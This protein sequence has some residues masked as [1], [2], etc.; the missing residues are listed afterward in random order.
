MLVHRILARKWR[1]AQVFVTGRGEV[2]DQMVRALLLYV[3][4]VIMHGGVLPIAD[5][6]ALGT[7]KTDI[8]IFRTS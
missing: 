5:F 7:G 4:P 3:T 1:G 8:G 6:E 2:P